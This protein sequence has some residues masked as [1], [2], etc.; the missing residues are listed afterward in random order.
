MLQDKQ[1][2]NQIAGPPYDFA[3]RVRNG[4]IRR[5]CIG[6]GH[7]QRQVISLKV[8]ILG[9]REVTAKLAAIPSNLRDQAMAAAIN[10][11]AEKARAEVNRAVRDEFVLT[12]EEVRNSLVLRRASRKSAT[13]LEATINIFGSKS[14]RGRSLNMIHFLA[15]IQAAGGAMKT[16]GA[17]AT[18]MKLKALGAQLGFAIRRGGG[19]KTIPGAFL[20]NKGRTIFHRV[21]KIR[22]PIEPLQVIGVSQMF[23]SER[24]RHRVMAKIDADLLVEMDRAIAMVLARNI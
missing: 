17:K 7:R 5:T 12:A 21:G 1:Q 19:L 4:A 16:R 24:I 13:T 8:E 14:K 22:L 18:K 23:N 3:L 20:G 2:R 11:T 9:M 10:K 15:A 6:L